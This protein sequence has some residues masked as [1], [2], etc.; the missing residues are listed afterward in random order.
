MLATEVHKPDAQFVKMDMVSLSAPVTLHVH[1]PAEG[2]SGFSRWRASWESHGPGEAV[3]LVDYAWVSPLFLGKGFVL[4]CKR[5][6]ASK[7]FFLSICT[8]RS[9][10]RR[11]MVMY[12]PLS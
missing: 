4:L 11:P 6:A 12:L 2:P 10:A 1:P 5:I 7:H 9:C 8:Q 3:L